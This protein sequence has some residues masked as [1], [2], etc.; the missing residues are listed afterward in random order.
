MERKTFRD[1]PQHTAA[2]RGLDLNTNE[3]GF[4]RK[5]VFIHSHHP[6]Y[7]I[8]YF[9]I[10]GQFARTNKNILFKP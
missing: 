6:E 7:I 10:T 1:V 5:I 2:V 3:S 9:S 4:D 8:S